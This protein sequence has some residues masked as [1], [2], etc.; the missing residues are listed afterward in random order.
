MYSLDSGKDENESFEDLES[1][2]MWL[3]SGSRS[4]QFLLPALKMQTFHTVTD[5][6]NAYV[7]SRVTELPYRPHIIFV[8]GHCTVVPQIL[9]KVEIGSICGIMLGMTKQGLAVTT[10]SSLKHRKSASV[11][12]ERTFVLFV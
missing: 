2:P 10:W 5:W 8:D 6:Y 3:D 4:Q 9:D 1:R 11:Q 12:V 7:S